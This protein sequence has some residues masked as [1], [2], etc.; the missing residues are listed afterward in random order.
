MMQLIKS[1]AD[2]STPFAPPFLKD[3]KVIVSHVANILFYLPE[4]GAG[5]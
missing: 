3:G 5:A 1:G 4:A 2:P